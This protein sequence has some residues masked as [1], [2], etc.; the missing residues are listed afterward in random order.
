MQLHE[1][2]LN[3]SDKESSLMRDKNYE[4]S[5]KERVISDYID[6]NR[7]LMEEVMG[8]KRDKHIMKEQIEKQHTLIMRYENR[9]VEMSQREN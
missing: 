2:I 4:L 7:E 6:E 3:C 1:A 5:E 8:L 9:G